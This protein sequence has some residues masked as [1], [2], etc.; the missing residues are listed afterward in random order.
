MKSAETKRYTVLERLYENYHFLA[1]TEE[2]FFKIIEE[3]I[4]NNI[5]TY[6]HSG[7]YFENRLNRSMN[8]I[9]KEQEEIQER[10]IKA[11]QIAI[12]SCNTFEEFI[13]FYNDSRYPVN[14]SICEEIIETSELLQTW[15]GTIIEQNREKVES[16]DF[17]AISYSEVYITFLIAYCE[18]YEMEY[19]N[20]ENVETRTS[21]EAY[22]H[23]I[24]QLD[25]SPEDNEILLEKAQNGDQKARN[26]FLEKNLRLALFASRGYQYIETP[27]EDLI[28]EA[29]MGLISASEKY[30]SKKSSSFSYYALRCMKRRIERFLGKNELLGQLLE[31]QY[32]LFQK[33]QKLKQKW[34][35]R[36]QKPISLEVIAQ[37]L[38]LSFSEIKLFEVLEQE[39]KY[40]EE[41]DVDDTQID[42]YIKQMD[43][44]TNFYSLLEQSHL[45]KVQIE[46]LEQY[47]GLKDGKPISSKAE[48]GR[49]LGGIKQQTIQE[50]MESALSRLRNSKYIKDWAYYMSDPEEALKN[51]QK[52]R[53]QYVK[54][55]ERRNAYGRKQ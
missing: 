54:K 9:L 33:Y 6:H 44:E 29:N 1:P 40:L 37:Q 8:E 41:T 25:I 43:F 16:G 18:L 52:F 21:L 14:V 12:A 39:I 13:Q 10:T 49:R 17:E 48:I 4:R 38:N 51:L 53:N 19:K 35:D 22:L 46:T 47:Y 27:V 7:Q 36:E 50:R 5:R 20:Q 23:D 15:I 3:E 24:N 31:T 28:Q 45:T 30:D 42:R 2:L 34:E 32:L 26:H 11:I 55:V